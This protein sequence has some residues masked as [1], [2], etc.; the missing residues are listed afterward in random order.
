MSRLLGVIGDPISHSLSPLIQNGWLRA[1]GIDANYMAM[2]VAPADLEGALKS[3]SDNR[4]AGLNVT[5]P[6]K[7]DVLKYASSRSALVQ[8]IGAA[9]C[10]VPDGASGW[11]AEN[12]DAPGFRETLLAADINVTGERVFVLGAGGAARAVAI[13]LSDLRADL[14]ICNRTLARADEMIEATGLDA[15]VLSLSDGLL[16]ARDARLVINTLSLGHDGKALSLPVGEGRVFYDISYGRAALQALTEARQKGWRTLDGLGMLVAQA[17]YSF[18]HW[19]GV[20]PDMA[21]AHAR[22]RR[23]VE[24]TS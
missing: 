13:T 5:L 3:L 24:A 17:A 23:A 10:L 12:T 9:N 11:R 2:Q 18:E 22:A 6:H 20:R 21:D 19:F 15:R 8:R 1:Y 4:F 7:Q 16:R 14:V